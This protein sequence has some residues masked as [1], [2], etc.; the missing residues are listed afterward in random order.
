MIIYNKGVLMP[1]RHCEEKL[2]I[3]TKQSRAKIL[4]LPRELKF[5]RND[6]FKPNF[7]NYA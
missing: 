6:A 1:N 5:A 2:K 4:R 7:K 3:L